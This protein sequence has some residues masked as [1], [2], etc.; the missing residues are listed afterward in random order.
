M[1]V[2]AAA[3]SL[4]FNVD[5]CAC[6]KGKPTVDRRKINARTSYPVAGQIRRQIRAGCGDSPL[7]HAPHNDDLPPRRAWG[8]APR[9]KGSATAPRRTRNKLVA[10]GAGR[11]GELGVGCCLLQRAGLA[12]V[13]TASLPVA[14]G[15]L[16]LLLLRVR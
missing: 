16:L 5:V 10:H 6:N 8:R 4:G 15:L 11:G 9:V 13:G 2:A 14:L 1:V 3:H 7:L 12:G